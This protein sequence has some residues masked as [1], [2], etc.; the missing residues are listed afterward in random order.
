MD[1]KYKQYDFV[2]S[3]CSEKFT[4]GMWYNK[5]GDAEGVA[6]PSCKAMNYEPFVEERNSSAMINTRTGEDW[7]KKIPGDFKDFMGTFAKRHS[8]Y[9][10][11]I[12]DHKSG[13][14][15]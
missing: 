7:T 2:C 11:T 8:K 13:R 12:D 6:C 15:Y 14:E 4:K 3:G 5:N 9:G 10:R 1:A